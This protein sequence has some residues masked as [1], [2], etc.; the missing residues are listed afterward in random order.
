MARGERGDLRQVGDTEELTARRERAEVLAD[1]ARR[2]APDP[3]VNLVENQEAA[4]AALLGL[5]MGD[6]EQREHHTRQLPAG[7]DLAQRP[8]GHTRVWGDPELGRV[9][10]ARASSFRARAQLDLEPRS[11]IASSASRV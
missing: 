7:C 6:A 1:G 9:P 8:G 5:A 10:P 3:R 11:P 4:R 2:V